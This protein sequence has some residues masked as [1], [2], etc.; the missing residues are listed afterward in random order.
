MPVQIEFNPIPGCAII[1]TS[2][3]GYHPRLLLDHL[4]VVSDIEESISEN[5][6]P[7]HVGVDPI[8]ID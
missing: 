7:F 4:F 6:E 2:S 1:L 5:E 3:T 8:R